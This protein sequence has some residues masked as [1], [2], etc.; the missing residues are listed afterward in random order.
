MRLEA[1]LP[2]RLDNQWLDRASEDSSELTIRALV[3]G[4]DPHKRSAT[5]EIMSAH[6]TILGGGRF[7]TDRDGYAAMLRY[8]RHWSDRVWAIAVTAMPSGPSTRASRGCRPLARG[9]AGTP[10]RFRRKLK[11]TA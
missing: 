2:S 4:M 10:R 1:A 9:W 6:E 11:Q 7:G 5:V 3:I 8:A